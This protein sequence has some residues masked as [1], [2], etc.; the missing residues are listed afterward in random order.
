[1]ESSQPEEDGRN[2]LNI[3]VVC[4][5]AHLGRAA[6]GSKAA[7]SMPLTYPACLDSLGHVAQRRA[8]QMAA[9]ALILGLHSKPA[10]FQ[11]SPVKEHTYIY[12]VYVVYKIKKI[13]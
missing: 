4:T 10:D 6:R 9:W 5:G 3:L 8:A 1:M 12:R 2:W 7:S 11:V 13:H